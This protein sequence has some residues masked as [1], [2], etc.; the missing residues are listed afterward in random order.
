MWRRDKPAVPSAGVPVEQ[1]FGDGDTGHSQRALVLV[2]RLLAGYSVLV[3]VAVILLALAVSKLVPLQKPFP[4][5]VTLSPK[6]DAVVSVEPL[7]RR[8]QGWEM[9]ERAWIAEYVR[10]REGIEPDREVMRLRVQP[11]GWV[12]TRS[13]GEVWN[14][15]RQRNQKL[16]VRALDRSATRRVTVD[17]LSQIDPHLWTVDF[18]VRDFEKGQEL[19]TLPLR[20]LVRV[21]YRTVE[22]DAVTF[23]NGDVPVEEIER[24]FGFV[25]VQYEP[26]GR[27]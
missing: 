18:T 19:Q 11:G 26:S 8:A 6:V 9:A 12:A 20:T 24:A 21:A 17:G 15:F 27:S 3:T 10:K 5:L 2:A 14:E 16:I 1:V 4:Y 23:S 25:V 7:S 22:F 13:T